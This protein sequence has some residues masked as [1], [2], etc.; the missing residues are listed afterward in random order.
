MY[1]DSC[2]NLINYRNAYEDSHRAVGLVAPGLCQL[3]LTRINCRG[4]PTFTLWCSQ[5]LMHVFALTMVRRFLY[6]QRANDPALLR[7]IKTLSPAC[8]SN[9]AECNL[10]WDFLYQSIITVKKS[11]QCSLHYL[12]WFPGNSA[13]ISESSLNASAIRPSTRSSKICWSL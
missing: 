13:S 7:G 5:M 12:D 3:I 8:L 4:T 1:T 11:M 2:S 10:F 6:H 9:V